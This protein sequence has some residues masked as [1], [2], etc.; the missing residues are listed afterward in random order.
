MTAARAE[1]AIYAVMR[2]VIGA[3]IFCHGFQKI[4]GV[5]GHTAPVGSQLWIGGLIELVGGGLV[6]LGLF[7]RIAAF[8]LSGE[9]AV[10]YFQF[11]WKLD[12]SH[13]RFVPLVNQGELAVAY[14]FVMLFFCARGSGPASLDRALGRSS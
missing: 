7:T 6:A 12:M 11:H 1:A 8:V 2:I 5:L 4:V 10:A 13:L 9:M 3:M 14:C